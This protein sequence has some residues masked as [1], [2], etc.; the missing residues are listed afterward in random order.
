MET[1]ER[2]MSCG[3]KQTKLRGGAVYVEREREMGGKLI[4]VD[5]WSCRY[6]QVVIFY[7]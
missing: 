2:G 5:K 4:M 6:I 3:G 1:E 7:R